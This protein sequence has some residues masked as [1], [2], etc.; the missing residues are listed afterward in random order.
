MN[1]WYMLL[2]CLFQMWENDQ[3][4]RTTMSVNWSLNLC[5]GREALAN[6]IL[7]CGRGRPFGRDQ[8]QDLHLVV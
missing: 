4:D 3:N 1:Y 6:S 5:L 2:T 8:L 7:H